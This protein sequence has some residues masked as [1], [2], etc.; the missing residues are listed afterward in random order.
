MAVDNIP[1]GVEQFNS[2][3]MVQAQISAK[4]DSIQ[5]L[6]GLIAQIMLEFQEL[7]GSPER[8]EGESNDD[9]AARQNKWKQSF[10]ALTARLEGAQKKLA[11]ALGELSKLQANDL[12]AATQDDAKK[13][14]AAL[15]S[16]MKSLQTMAQAMDTTSEDLGPEE[17]SS[18]ANLKLSIK[19]SMVQEDVDGV[20]FNFVKLTVLGGTGGAA[21]GSGIQ[22]PLPRNDGLTA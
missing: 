10:V 4:M 21:V 3:S 5:D 12:P 9:Y 15:E 14:K 19:A 17:T 18:G 2:A 6:N 11:K 13:T 1:S 8:K 16:Q 22:A 20:E 7:G